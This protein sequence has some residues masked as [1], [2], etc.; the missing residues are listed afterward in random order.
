MNSD[1]EFDASSGKPLRNPNGTEPTRKKQ[2]SIA[3]PTRPITRILEKKRSS[4]IGQEDS[5]KPP[6]VTSKEERGTYGWPGHGESVFAYLANNDGER[7][8]ER[9]ELKAR[10]WDEDLFYWVAVEAGAQRI[11][12]RCLESLYGDYFVLWFGHEHH[13]QGMGVTAVAYPIPEDDNCQTDDEESDHKIPPSDL[14]SSQDRRPSK[15]DASGH[16]NPVLRRKETSHPEYSGQASHR[17]Y[18]ALL[19]EAEQHYRYPRA[20]EPAFAQKPG[21]ISVGDTKDIILPD[22]A[23]YLPGAKSVISMSMIKARRWNEK[24]FFWRLDVGSARHVVKLLGRNDASR[25]LYLPWL[26]IKKEFDEALKIR[27]PR[28][29]PPHDEKCR[30]R[31]T[32]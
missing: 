20:A 3:F 19:R 16:E 8:N 17:H 27:E 6:F 1:Y 15:S 21:S 7:I 28:F 18:N 14:A 25:P 31:W 32:N 23:G 10:E 29:T 22:A 4:T 11:V 2:D 24:L 5:K 13:L 30:R 9:I 26:G 12:R